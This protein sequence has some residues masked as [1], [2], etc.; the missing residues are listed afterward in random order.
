MKTVAQLLCAAKNEIM[1]CRWSV[2][3]FWLDAAA[4]G[5]QSPTNVGADKNKI[6]QQQNPDAVV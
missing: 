6:Q 3:G 5:E 2:C 4:K 1:V